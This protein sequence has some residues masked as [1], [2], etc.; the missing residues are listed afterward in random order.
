MEGDLP[1]DYQAETWKKIKAIPVFLNVMWHNSNSTE[2]ISVKAAHNK[3]DI[4]FQMNWVDKTPNKEPN[5]SDG[6]AIQFPV[7]K[8]ADAGDLPFIGMGNMSNPVQIWK[9]KPSGEFEFT[10]E[11][12]INLK[13]KDGA[14]KQITAKGMYQ[15]G[16]WHIVIKRPLTVSDK[17]SI[18]FEK[19]GYLSFAVWDGQ[20]SGKNT[21]SKSFSEWLYY[22]IE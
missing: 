22:N 19:R 13:K 4:A 20:N 2:W 10:A 6:V 3:K 7:K 14:Q 9:W 21:K 5:Q 12:V 8:I 1:L 18:Q 16:A 11:G 15:N 17:A